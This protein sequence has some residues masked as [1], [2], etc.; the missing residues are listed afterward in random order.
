M[1]KESFNQ[2]FA[3]S[4][5][6]HPSVNKNKISQLLETTKVII[7]PNYFQVSPSRAHK[8]LY[9]QDR[10]TTK[11]EAHL[12]IPIGK[13][14]WIQ[15]SGT[16]LGG[17]SDRPISSY[18]TMLFPDVFAK[19]K[20]NPESFSVEYFL[21]E[22]KPLEV[23]EPVFGGLEEVFKTGNVVLDIASGEAVADIQL[24]LKYPEVTLIGTDIL[25]KAEKKVHPNRAGLQLTHDDWRK[26]QNIPS[27]TVDAIL[28][29]QGIAMWGFP[30]R[31]HDTSEE[32]GFK[33]IEA[34]ERISKPGTIMRLDIKNDFLVKNIGKNW[35][36]DPRN[37]VFI[38]RRIS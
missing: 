29:V 7:D 36:I 1:A 8:F 6:E 27:G 22:A 10:S 32:D 24:A 13:N 21:Q 34:I 31:G 30:G 28:S 19:P 33:I 5:K 26:L 11:C 14:G 37:D 38:A 23:P 35:E 4:E 3:D 17:V 12:K 2:V 18:Q 20:S 25:Y 15:Y 16:I 9:F